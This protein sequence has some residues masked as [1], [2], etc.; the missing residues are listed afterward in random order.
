MVRR[1]SYIASNKLK[2]SSIK[3][4][5]KPILIKK[6]FKSTVRFRRNYSTLSKIFKKRYS[7]RKIKNSNF[8][9]VTNSFSWAKFYLSLT[10]YEKRNQFREIL[11]FSANLTQ[12]NIKA[13][14]LSS[15]E[16]SRAKFTNFKP[17]SKKL[18]SL[19]RINNNNIFFSSKMNY[20]FL[21]NFNWGISIASRS[22][23]LL[24]AQRKIIVLTILLQ[25]F[26]NYVVI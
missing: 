7:F 12:N 5:L 17:K 10:F 8:T 9:L 13:Q 19:V 15:A 2:H 22:Y 20:D 11:P 23:S 1:W 3:I 26:K 18:P 25:L 21:L 14:I 4:K 6:G 16:H 24:L